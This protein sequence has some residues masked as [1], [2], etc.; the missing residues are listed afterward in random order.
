MEV[1]CFPPLLAIP[2]IFTET[3]V[4]ECVQLVGIN[5]VPPMG[6]A[7]GESHR[8]VWVNPEALIIR[9]SDEHIIVM[10]YGIMMMLGRG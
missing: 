2:Y 5:C 4:C 7:L 9:S 6:L 3:F 8:S 10:L 1:A